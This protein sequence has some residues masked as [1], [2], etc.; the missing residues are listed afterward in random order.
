[1]KLLIN[2]SNL[3]NGGAHQVAISLIYEL[4]FLEFEN[5]Y[6]VILHP[7]FQ[8]KIDSSKYPDNFLFRFI[9]KKSIHDGKVWNDA[10]VSL[11]L[12][13]NQQ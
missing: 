6:Q 2:L 1:M 13:N 7:S 3:Q 10:V 5:T 9:K 11:I 12:Q 4:S 8:N